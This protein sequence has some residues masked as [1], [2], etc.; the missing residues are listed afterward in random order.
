MTTT[1][2]KG[3]L[4]CKYCGRR[5]LWR[6]RRLYMCNPDFESWARLHDFD[7][8]DVERLSDDQRDFDRMNIRESPAAT[9]GQGL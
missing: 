9:Q 3:E 6:I 8:N 4:R 1:A 7:P 5:A 2:K